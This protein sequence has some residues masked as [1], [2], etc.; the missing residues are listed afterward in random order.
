MPTRLHLVVASL[1]L[2]SSCG[3]PWRLVETGDTS[4][5]LRAI[6][7]SS[8]GTMYIA[9]DDAY[10][11]RRT[12]RNP[13]FESVSLLDAAG[14]HVTGRRILGLT[15]VA[16]DDVYAWTSG[17]GWHGAGGSLSMMPPPPGRTTGTEALSWAPGGFVPAASDRVLLVANVVDDRGARNLLWEGTARGGFR[18]ALFVDGAGPEVTWAAG[19]PSTPLVAGDAAG[20]VYRR[21][22]TQ[23]SRLGSLPFGNVRMAAVSS[24]RLFVAT[25]DAVRVVRLDDVGAEESGRR[26][27]GHVE[28]LCAFPG[29]RA[30]AVGTP[31]L[32]RSPVWVFEGDAW[33]NPLV[34][35]RETL[36]G[37]WCAEDGRA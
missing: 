27:D 19:S 13:A 25:G 26:L 15:G 14:K 28:G 18:E 23:W 11:A 35:T 32:G 9:G 31:P 4:T 5:S 8:S 6:W 12:S 17:T 3:P 20:A 24:D 2:V 22:Q 7:V 16:D 30:V 37:V 21:G 36:W 29:G 33:S 34:G 10:L 1:A